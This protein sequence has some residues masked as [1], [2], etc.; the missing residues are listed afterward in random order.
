M[1]DQE[2]T[3]A[4]ENDALQY[5]SNLTGQRIKVGYGSG[6]KDPFAVGSGEYS[7]E[8]IIKPNKDKAE[9][10][11]EFVFSYSPATPRSWEEPGSD[12]EIEIYDIKNQETNEK[13][14]WDELSNEAQE[15]LEEAAS[16]ELEGQYSYNQGAYEDHMDAEREEQLMR[17]YD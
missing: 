14:E 15:K 7:G 12:A 17:Q 10:D 4:S 3:F 1:S 9:I 11:V 13:F 16:N 5:L 2:L 6:T 8:T